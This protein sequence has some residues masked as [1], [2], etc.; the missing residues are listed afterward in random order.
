ME[1][2]KECVKSAEPSQSLPAFFFQP[3]ALPSFFTSPSPPLAFPS[4]ELTPISALRK[5]A[6]PITRV[7]S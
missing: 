3:F 6:C 2:G 4:E 1:V 5:G 7:K